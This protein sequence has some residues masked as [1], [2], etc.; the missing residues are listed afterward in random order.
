VVVV[1]LG[2]GA[3][4]GSGEDPRDS[5]EDR[6]IGLGHFKTSLHCRINLPQA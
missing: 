5:F 3:E 4:L 6:A 1:A 2:V